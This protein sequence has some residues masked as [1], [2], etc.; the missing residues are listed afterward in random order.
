MVNFNKTVYA[1]M[2]AFMTFTIVETIGHRIFVE[3]A[4]DARIC[5]VSKISKKKALWFSKLNLLVS[6]L[7]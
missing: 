4:S 3:C 7:Q 6:K 5:G 2:V 1:R